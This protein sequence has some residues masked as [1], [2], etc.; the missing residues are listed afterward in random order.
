MKIRTIKD[1]KKAAQL[2]G[3]ED[4]DALTIAEALGISENKE[5]TKR[6][7]LRQKV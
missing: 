2:I 6:D 7:I 1:C 3:A 4:I 5:K